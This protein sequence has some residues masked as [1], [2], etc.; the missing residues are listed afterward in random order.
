MG[1]KNNPGAFDCYEHA[2]PDEPMFV[3]LGRDPIGG[4]IVRA[5]A[6][7]R[8][9]LAKTGDAAKIT[10]AVQCAAAMDE[11]CDKAGRDPW[12]SIFPLLPLDVLAHELQERGA[13]VV[14]PTTDT[15]PSEMV[16]TLLATYKTAPALAE[17]LAMRVAEYNELRADFEFERERK[18][19]AT[20]SAR[21]KELESAL[22][23]VNARLGD[24]QS[25][26]APASSG[27]C[28]IAAERVRQVAREGWTP[29]HDDEH[30]AGELASAGA[31]YAIHAACVLHPFDGNGLE[32]IGEVPWWPWDKSWWKPK[33]PRRD[34][35]RAGALLAAELDRLDRAEAKR[36]PKPAAVAA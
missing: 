16:E 34:L 31:C 36:E 9:H 25:L 28:A 14:R 4:A 21:I 26:A 23:T 5:W 32:D 11:W 20:L 3:I 1:T 29:E 22:A 35:V 12:L 6:A 15:E 18:A 27:A 17:A 19:D 13:L 10:E 7:A 2:H 8:A 24:A 30:D 33:D